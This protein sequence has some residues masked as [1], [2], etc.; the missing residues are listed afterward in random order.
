MI[1]KIKGA[2]FYVKSTS[3]GF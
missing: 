1:F 3:R 2:V